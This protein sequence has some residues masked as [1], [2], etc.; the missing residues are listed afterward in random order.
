M[1]EIKQFTDKKLK[2][3]W[4]NAD[5]GNCSKREIIIKT[6]SDIAEGYH[7]GSTSMAICKELE[8][9][10]ESSRRIYHLTK[11]GLEVLLD[12]HY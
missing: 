10:K 4:D 5:F 1:P 2:E 9:I 3:V 11:L 12:N 7:C 8:L 6:L